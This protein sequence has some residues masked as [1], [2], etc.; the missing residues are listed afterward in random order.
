LR[1]TVDGVEVKVDF[2]QLQKDKKTG[3]LSEKIA[4]SYT[5]IAPK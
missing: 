5:I 3:L 2:I 1:I 4:D